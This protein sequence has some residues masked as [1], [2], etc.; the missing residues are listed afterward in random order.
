MLTLDVSLG[1]PSHVIFTKVEQDAILLN[2][3]TNKYFVLEEVGERLWELLNAG[4]SLRKSYGMLLDEY[5]VEPVQLEQDLLSLLAH[6]TENG[7]VEISS[8]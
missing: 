4:N 8:G 6:L 5:D 1:I 3:R 2:T 7:L